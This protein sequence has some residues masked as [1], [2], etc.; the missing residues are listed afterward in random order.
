MNRIYKLIH[1]IAIVFCGVL[2]YAFGKFV[3]T[4]LGMTCALYIE[5]KIGGI[6]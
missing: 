5:L 2:V 4:V 3:G 6:L 1:I